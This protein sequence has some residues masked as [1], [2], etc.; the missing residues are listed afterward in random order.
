MYSLDEIALI[1]HHVNNITEFNIVVGIL[2]TY[3]KNFSIV[4]FRFIE[5]II[6]KKYKT[7]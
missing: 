6:S 3:E 1:F 2:D 4:N 5:Q 7:L